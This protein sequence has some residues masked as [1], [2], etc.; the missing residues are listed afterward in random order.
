M[1]VNTQRAAARIAH[2]IAE[3]ARAQGWKGKRGDALAMEMAVGALAAT[4]AYLGDD[5][6]TTNAL[7]MFAFIVSTRGLDYV[8]ERAE[9]NDGKP[10]ENA[11]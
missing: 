4:I 6:P 9:A 1:E 5:H 8:R 3:R 7:S 11:A 2:S 10:Q